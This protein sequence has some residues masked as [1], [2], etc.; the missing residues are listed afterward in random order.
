MKQPRL[1]RTLI[2][3]VCEVSLFPQS[4]HFFGKEK[5]VSGAYKIVV[6]G[7]FNSG[8]TAFVKTISDIDVVTT[9]RRLTSTE[10]GVKALTTVA[11]D[12][13]RVV[14]DGKTLHLYGTPGQARFDFMWE[15][16]AREMHGFIVLIDSTDPASFPAAGE[17]IS[18]FSAFHSVPYL[19][20]ANK[21]D[22][23][24]TLPLAQIRRDADISQTTTVIPCIAI[25]KASVRQVLRHL[26]A[27][28]DRAQ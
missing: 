1:E 27:L 4:E 6:T 14:L 10:R 19:L 15:I 2:S 23:R 16:L 28:I 17:L 9:E 26:I 13:G 18:I 5:P 8:K 24:D 7:P 12:Y 20:V 25:Q 21:T 11:M 3:L 22:L